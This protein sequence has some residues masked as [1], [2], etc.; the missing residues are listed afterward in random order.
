MERGDQVFSKAH[1]CFRGA[2][3]SNHTTM[4]SKQ[5][6]LF[7]IPLQFNLGLLQAGDALAG[8]GQAGVGTGSSLS[9]HAPQRMRE[10]SQ[11]LNNQ[12][13]NN[14]NKGNVREEWAD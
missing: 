10:H 5:K 1:K 12:P 7:E 8:V 3:I 14:G 6:L 4:R 9:L 2:V 11:D 13:L